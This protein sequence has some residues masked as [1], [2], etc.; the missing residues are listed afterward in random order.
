MMILGEG[1]GNKE[2]SNDDQ[3]SEKWRRETKKVRIE[4]NLQVESEG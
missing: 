4:N 2:K 1:K 3:T